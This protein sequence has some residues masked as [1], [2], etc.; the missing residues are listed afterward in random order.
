MLCMTAS[1]R[2]HDDKEWDWPDADWSSEQE[3]G[4]LYPRMFAVAK[5]VS[6]SYCAAHRD[7]IRANL[8]QTRLETGRSIK[9]GEGQRKLTQLASLDERSFVNVVQKVCYPDTAKLNWP[10]DP[11][12]FSNP[13]AMSLNYRFS[14]PELVDAPSEALPMHLPCNRSDMYSVVATQ[15]RA[16]YSRDS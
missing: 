8:D 2:S 1:T 16:A 3:C 6:K 4:K 9:L 13:A 12:Q 11:D 7:Q 5:W 14:D 10:V 15:P